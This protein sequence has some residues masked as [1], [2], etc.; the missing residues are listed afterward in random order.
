MAYNCKKGRTM[1]MR[2][3][4][5]AIYRSVQKTATV[6]VYA[7]VTVRGYR[8]LR[9]ALALL[10]NLR[11]CDPGR[12]RRGSRQPYVC[13]NVAHAKQVYASWWSSSHALRGVLALI[14]P[15]RDDQRRLQDAAPQVHGRATVA[16][17]WLE[18]SP[19]CTEAE[20][21]R[22]VAHGSNSYSGSA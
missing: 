7:R 10:F 1:F 21:R 14:I 15:G 22:H 3:T 5:S 20:S 8:A 13:S 4:R 2:S 11:R 6:L 16:I 12:R 19:L 17:V 9:W 18:N